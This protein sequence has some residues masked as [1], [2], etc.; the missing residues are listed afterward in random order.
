MT[1]SRT[2]TLI[3]IAARF[4]VNIGGNGSDNVQ[5]PLFHVQVPLTVGIFVDL[6]FLQDAVNSHF[7]Q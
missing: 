6:N 4:R 1:P 7:R 5:G 3:Y 2:A